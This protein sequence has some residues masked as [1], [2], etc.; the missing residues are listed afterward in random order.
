MTRPRDAASSICPR[1]G[2]TQLSARSFDRAPLDARLGILATNACPPPVPSSASAAAADRFVSAKEG[3]LRFGAGPARPAL[4]DVLTLIAPRCD[5][6][7]PFHV[8]QD[9]RLVDIWPI[10]ARGY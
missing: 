1:A 10:D 7:D 5:L 4:G 6:H 3:G 9:G 2:R 8:M